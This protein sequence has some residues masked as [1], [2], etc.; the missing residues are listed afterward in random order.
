MTGLIRSSAIRNLLSNLWLS[1]QAVFNSLRLRPGKLNRFHTD[2]LQVAALALVSIG[3]GIAAQWIALKATGSARLKFNPQSLESEV[4]YLAAVLLCSV[5]TAHLVKRHSDLRPSKSVLFVLIVGASTL[6]IVLMRALQALELDPATTYLGQW[7]LLLW[8][9]V[10]L[11]INL[12]RGLHLNAVHSLLAISPLLLVFAFHQRYEP[13]EFWEERQATIAKANP[14]TEDVLEK[15]STLLPSHIAALADQ[16][17]QVRDVYFLGFAPFATEDVFSLEL[18]AIFPMMEQRFDTKGR[19]LRLS[20]HLNSL[21]K[22]PFASVTNLRKALFAVAARMDAQED[23][24]VMYVTSHGSRQY[25]IASRLPPIDFN[26][27][28]PQ[29]LRT[30]LD[31]AGIKNRVL[32]ISACYSGGFIEPLKDDNTLIMTAAAAD[33]PSFGCG[34]S[35][36]FTYFGKA[37]M[38][39]QLRNNTLSFEQ[40]FKNALPI[41]AQREKAMKFDSSNPQISVGQAIAP[42]LKAL[43]I[44]L[45]SRTKL[46]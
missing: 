1:W 28:N 19:S 38:D 6:Q 39:E 37:V 21:D 23:I 18:D 12:I 22:Y 5:I 7:F 3:V 34:A 41:L 31:A 25:E 29:V 14:V 44:E 43:E 20:N 9:Y 16:R 24:F 17:P 40:A 10:L 35:S 30:L 11:L 33:R 13:A 45:S 32:I 46:N 4:F 8:F 26:E 36:T 15:Q 27:I 42:K 2:G